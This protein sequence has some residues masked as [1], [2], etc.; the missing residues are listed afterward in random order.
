MNYSNLIPTLK[1]DVHPFSHY[2]DEHGKISKL[3]T[4]AGIYAFW[5]KNSKVEDRELLASFNRKVFIKGKQLKHLKKEIPPVH[6]IHEVNWD[7]NLSD[8]Y[9]CLYVG[10]SS[11]IGGRVKLHLGS[12][13]NSSWYSKDN[14]GAYKTI[15]ADKH[16]D[17]F[18]LK[19]DT[20]CQLRAGM[21][22]LLSLR[23]PGLQFG[24][25]LRSHIC[26]SIYTDFGENSH[27]AMTERFYAEDLAIGTFRPWFNVDSER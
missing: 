21:E 7:W 3:T 5:W 11:N 20:A 26:I 22:H 19:W 15:R 27:I 13:H 25:L 9:V 12:S 1:K 4:E 23:T 14:L 16:K 18:L 17:G 24:T 2:L 10:K 8:E 6:Q